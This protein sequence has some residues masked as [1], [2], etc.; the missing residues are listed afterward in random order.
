MG[1][2]QKASG[3]YF[4]VYGIISRR[5][6][7]TDGKLG[8][9][10]PA[11]PEPGYCFRQ[12]QLAGL[13]VNRVVAGCLRSPF[14]GLVWSAGVTAPVPGRIDCLTT[15]QQEKEKIGSHTG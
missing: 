12:D 11:G 13:V 8:R 6:G 7:L 5:P 10:L 2:W 3:T 15:L 4:P 14:H 1:R 9:I